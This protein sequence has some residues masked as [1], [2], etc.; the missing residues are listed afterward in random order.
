MDY[1]SVLGPID[2]QYGETGL[3]G[4]GYLA[5]FNELKE[6]INNSDS[7]IMKEKS[8]IKAEQNNPY[9]KV[10]DDAKRQLKKLGNVEHLNDITDD[11][12]SHSIS[13]PFPYSNHS[14]KPYNFNSH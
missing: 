14:E 6:Q 5:K 8:Q 1:Y 11:E 7:S 12:Q 3:S 10:F 4:V 9:E 13:I 2:P